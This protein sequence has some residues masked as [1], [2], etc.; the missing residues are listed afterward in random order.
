MAVRD[1]LRA[2]SVIIILS[3]GRFFDPTEPSNGRKLIAEHDGDPML[4]RIGVM[5]PLHR[6]QV[7]AASAQRR[8][9]SIED[10]RFAPGNGLKADI[11]ACPFCASSRLAENEK[12]AH[13]GGLGCSMLLCVTPRSTTDLAS[14][15]R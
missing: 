5:Q 12:A 13:G 6:H 10:V 2:S 4:A 9:R 11:A 1:L 8:D 7:K 3:W 14:E 15:R